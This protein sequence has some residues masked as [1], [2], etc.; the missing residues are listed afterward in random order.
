MPIATTVRAATADELAVIARRMDHRRR[1]MAGVNRSRKG[2]LVWLGTFFGCAALV[3]VVLIVKWPS[4]PLGFGLVM[5]SLFSILSAIGLWKDRQRVALESGGF[6]SDQADR[7]RAVTDYRFATDRIVAATGED[8]DLWWLFRLADGK[9]LV[10]ELGQ[11]EDIDPAAQSWHRDVTIGVDAHHTVVSIA[12]AGAPVAVERR[13]LQPPDYMTTPQT[14]FWSPP[15]DMGP[16]PAVMTTD[17]T[18]ANS[19]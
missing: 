2:E 11:W 7:G 1:S 8:G 15:D 13:D 12:S 6:D 3:L 17:P 14:L 16:L 9:W 10:F 19:G 4:V 18:A 5:C